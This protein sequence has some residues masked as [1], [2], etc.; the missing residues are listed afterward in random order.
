[1]VKQLADAFDGSGYD[2]YSYVIAV[3]ICRDNKIARPF[4]V[5]VQNR[6]PDD[7][8]AICECHLQ[9]QAGRVLSLQIEI[10]FLKLGIPI[11]VPNYKQGLQPSKRYLKRLA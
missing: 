1:M 7:H 8:F 10:P 4:R 9:L 5:I 6:G 2:K 11:K 3:R